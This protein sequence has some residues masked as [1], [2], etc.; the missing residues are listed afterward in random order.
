MMILF[1]RKDCVDQKSVLPTAYYANREPCMAILRTIL[2][3]SALFHC[4]I[5]KSPKDSRIM[6]VAC[7]G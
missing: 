1:S 6:N 7:V 2:A 3:S 5:S 4:S